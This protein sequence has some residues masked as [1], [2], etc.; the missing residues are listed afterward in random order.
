MAAHLARS[1]AVAAFVL[2]SLFK[3]VRM[4]D[5]LGRER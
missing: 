5:S 2:E 4:A 3:G 1:V